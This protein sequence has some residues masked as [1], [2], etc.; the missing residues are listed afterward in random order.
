MIL[1]MGFIAVGTQL[2]MESAGK[3]CIASPVD[4]IEGPFV[5]LKNGDS[6]RINDAETAMKYKD[7]VEKVLSLGDILITYGD[8]K[9]SNSQLKPTSYVEEYWEDAAQID[10]LRFCGRP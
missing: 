2:K 10:G 5:R 8:F 6:L 3:G 7:D 9:K 1:T 4:S